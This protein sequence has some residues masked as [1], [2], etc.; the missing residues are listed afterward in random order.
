MC[1]N[2]SFIWVQRGPNFEQ[3][4]VACRQCW[5]CRQ[6]RVNDYVAR[7]LAEAST[8]SV[9]AT[10]TLT[11]APRDD[12]AD[13]VLHPRHF[14]LFM[15]LLRRA[16]HKVRYLVAGEYGDL[17]GRAHFH[18]LLFFQH[19]EPLGDR[20]TVPAYGTPDAPFCREI[21]QKRMVHI[22]EW[23]HGH[24]TVD[25][26]ASEKSARYVCKYL[27]ADNK[28]NAWF[29]LSKKPALGAAWFARKAALAR[30]LGVLPSSFEYLPPGGSKDKRYLMTGATRRDYLDAITQDD[31]DREK[32][33]EWVQ[34]SFDK[35]QLR[36]MR[37][38]FEALPLADQIE[39]F[40]RIFEAIQGQKDWMMSGDR[41]RQRRYIEDLL[42]QSSDGI[43][44][45]SNHKTE[46]FQN[47]QAPRQTD[48][49][50]DRDAG[51]GNL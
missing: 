20:G 24:I 25:W 14:Q 11:Y 51:S 30:E 36:R 3:Q 13:K 32:M 4:E 33:S 39:H 47:G 50:P 16:G 44:W 41:E 7:S 48:F 27:L 5:R 2:P 42:A 26:S 49:S 40:E 19:L 12:L 15:K 46:G 22:R 9:T 34:K 28:N 29:S 8:S 37:E 1:I 23:P 21:P 45:L 31:A 10:V 17:R 43:L 6:N 35:A 18:A 38:R